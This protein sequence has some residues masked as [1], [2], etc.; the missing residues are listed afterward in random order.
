ML[1][2]SLTRIS[3]LSGAK[4]V[5][6]K[7]SPEVMRSAVACYHILCLSKT[8]YYPA[9]VPTSL[10]PALRISGLLWHTV[11]SRLT[12]ACRRLHGWPSEPQI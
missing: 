7:T 12:G 3:R 2:A 8:T 6:A 5:D 11:H 1:L 4:V 9:A 10:P